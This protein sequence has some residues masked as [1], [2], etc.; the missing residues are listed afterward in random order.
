M[1]QRTYVNGAKYR[2][3]PLRVVH[4]VL[5]AKRETTAGGCWLWCG[6]TTHDGYGFTKY[7]MP[8]KRI[9]VPVASVM[10]PAP[11][12]MSGRTAIRDQR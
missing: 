4:R 9:A 6:Q 12:P 1:A 3:A 5:A 7:R 10:I 11:K 8:G 2:D